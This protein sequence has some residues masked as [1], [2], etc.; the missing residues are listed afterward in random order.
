MRPLTVADFSEEW[1]RTGSGRV[2]GELAG[3]VLTFWSGAPVDR[4]RGG[5]HGAVGNDGVV[6][7]GE[8]T[9]LIVDRERAAA[10][11]TW[12]TRMRFR[13]RVDPQDLTGRA[14]VIGGT[15][16]AVAALSTQAVWHDPW[17]G[18]V[19]GGWG[20]AAVLPHPGSERD[21]AEAIVDEV[22]GI[23]RRRGRAGELMLRAV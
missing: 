22:E 19:A 7:D 2:L 17:P 8:R 3:N 21:W 12:L 16:A 1:L 11:L 18:I 14:Y 13:L 23:A 15:A 6:D 20:Y 10:L 4:D 5:F 9:W